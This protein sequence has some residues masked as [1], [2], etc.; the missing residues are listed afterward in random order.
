MSSPT[1]SIVMNCYNSARYLKQAL[2]SVLNQSYEDWELIF[3]DNQSTDQSA[4]IFQS[5]L[6]PRF[7]YHRANAHTTLGE[8]R[9]LAASKASGKWIAFMDC[10]DTWGAEKLE[11]QISQVSKYGNDVGLVYGLVS[12][13]VEDAQTSSSVA[14]FY[15]RLDIH[16]HG[17][18]NI[19]HRLLIGN[20]IIFSSVM[21][22][23]MLFQQV[24]GIDPTLRQNEDYDLLLKVACL[25]KAVCVDKECVVYRI[26]AK[27]NSHTQSE[28]AY[29]E[30]EQILMKL[31]QSNEVNS[32]IA[33]NYSRYAIYKISKGQL[34]AG[35]GLLVMKGSIYWVLKRAIV[36]SIISLRRVR[37]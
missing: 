21:I 25:S 17:A 6:E 33:L 14:K 23:R 26:H 1:I 19:F 8:A 32:A 7:K 28:L 30:S 31:P 15:S 20:F 16:P 24:G 2:E 35:I 11:L 34:L 5:Y 37:V 10:D 27:N 3:W 4:N 18:Q 29:Q 13:L 22:D 12:Y 36:R 9:N